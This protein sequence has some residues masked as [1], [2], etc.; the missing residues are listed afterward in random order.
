M[1]WITVL[2]SMIAAACLSLAAAHL[3]VW[4]RLR[5]GSASPLLDARV[6]RQ[7]IADRPETDQAVVR[8]QNREAAAPVVGDA[9]GERVSGSRRTIKGKSS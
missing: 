6:S 7:G 2:W 1:N 8:M 4:L 9:A 3:L 5:A